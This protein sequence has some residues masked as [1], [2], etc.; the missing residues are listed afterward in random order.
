[1]LSELTKT[2]PL[3]LY[4]HSGAFGSGLAI[5]SAHPI[6]HTHTHPYSLN[7][8]PV[9]VHHGDWIVAKAAGCAT[10]RVDKG[11]LGEVDVWVTHVSGACSF[12]RVAAVHRVRA[13]RACTSW[14]A[15]PGFPAS[16]NREQRFILSEGLKLPGLASSD[17]HNDFLFMSIRYRLSQQEAK[18]DRSPIERIVS[19]KRTS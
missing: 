4:G 3:P 1:M 18:T 12:V 2:L 19:V 5:L 17:W 16:A 6:V 8:H 11:G 14:C 10:L 13:Y 7:G 15:K 9:H